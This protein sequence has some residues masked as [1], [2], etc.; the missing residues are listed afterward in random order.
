MGVTIETEWPRLMRLTAAALIG[1]A[2]VWMVLLVWDFTDQRSAW[3]I[4][5][6]S[7][8]F[9]IPLIELA[10]LLI[11]MA[12]GFS[13]VQAISDLPK[14]T[15]IAALAWLTIAAT[16][17]FRTG[18]DHLAAL[19]G[20]M[21][22]FIASL[23]LLALVALRR[24]GNGRLFSNIWFGVGCGTVI[25]AALWLV[26]IAITTPTGEEWV[27]LV[28][29]VNNVRHI[30]HFAFSGFFAAIA[31]LILL[32]DNNNLLVRWGPPVL[33]AALSMGLALWPGSRGPTLAIAAGMAVIWLLGSGFRRQLGL[34]FGASL[35]LSLGVVAL[36]PVPH[37]IYG[38]FGAT[39]VADVEAPAGHDA[40]S[41]RNELWRQTFEKIE[42]R[43][44]LG[45]GVEQFSA[46]GPKD[47]L[48][49]RHPHNFLL[50][51]SFSG[52]L[53]SALL[54]LLIMCSALRYWRWPHGYGIGLVGI[55]GFVGII[56]Y[57]MYDGALFFSYPIMIFLLAIASAV[58]PLEKQPGRDR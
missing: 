6:R 45:W 43:P 46:F 7:N 47:S 19:I 40:S 51:I 37:P 35:I 30:G 56:V 31:C 22:L 38:I 4:F 18:S 34:F 13:P 1:C 39:G 17:S 50:Q 16:I 55:G 9:A 42:E 12:R 58:K 8:S 54:A 44:W 32:R 11:V 48:G 49:T 53:V 33:L 23:F 14:L 20:L 36:L 28:P 27:I 2:P 24:N 5:V 10:F 3:Q 41:G 25:Y 57:S 29:G 21:K 52:G 15:K 26:H